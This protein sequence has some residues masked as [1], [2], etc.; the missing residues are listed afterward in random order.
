MSGKNDADLFKFPQVVV[1]EASAGSGKTLA[2][3][4]RYLELL[5][6]PKLSQVPIPL[7]SVLAITF[8]NKATLEMKERILELLKKIALDSFSSPKEKEVILNLLG[9]DEKKAKYVASAIVDRIMHNYN[10]FQV[11]TIDSFINA[12]LLGCAL[13]IDRSGSFK[14]K[15]NYQEQLAFCLDLVIDQAPEKKEVLKLLEEFLDHYLFVEN[16]KGWFPKEDILGLMQSLFSL[17]NKQGRPFGV[18]KGKSSE[19][20]K[21]KKHIYRQIFELAQMFPRGMNATAVKSIEN[22]LDKSKDIFDIAQIP[23][24]FADSNPPLNKS[25]TASEEFVAAWRKTNKRLVE[26]VELDATV[27]YNAYITLFHKLLDSFQIIS[28][29]EDLLFLEELNRK[30]RLLFDQEGLTVSEAYYRLATRFKH[31]LIDEFQDTSILQWRNLEMM[32]EDALASGGSLF[33]VGDKKQAI[34]RFRGG[35]AALFDEIKVKF[36][37]YNVIPRQ[38]TNNWRSQKA[39]IDFN[40]LVFSRDNLAKALSLSGIKKSLGNSAAAVDE[41]LDIFKDAVQKGKENNSSG[42]VSIEPLNEKNQEERNQIMQLKIVNL[43]RELAK[44]FRYE[45]IALLTRNNSE[46]ELIS[47]WLLSENIPVES[48]K[49]LNVIENPLI[50]EIICFLK[51]LHSPIS[52]LNFAGFILGEIFTKITGISKEEIRDFIF[53]INSKDKYFNQ[54]YLYR[55]FSKQYPQLWV[56]YCQEFFKNV[57]FISVYELT[58]SIYQRL[59]VFDKFP[60]QEAFFLKFLELIKKG[61]SEYSGL[62]GFLEYLA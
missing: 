7:A 11:Q 46:V 29:K 35:E 50:K 26:L 9:L 3:A 38:L 27:A 16:R 19:V 40:N 4:K 39:I 60:N 31:Y 58:A 57:G 34:Y 36:S 43:I 24:S 37:R 20:I 6:N 62:G 54:S 45:D 52:D 15:R 28:K 51:F 59:G 23:Q 10:F 32:V 44:R 49:T 53:E 21:L 5:I 12:L 42:Y 41:I 22:F 18:Y 47:S 13:N 30:V 61:E 17:S 1:V 2:L 14:I 8:T 25:K 55:K 48:E 33:Y 56:N